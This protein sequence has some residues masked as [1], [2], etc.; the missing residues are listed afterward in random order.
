MAS[1]MALSSPVSLFQL[2]MLLFSFFFFFSFS[3]S[4]S[5][6]LN[7]TTDSLSLSFP[8]TSLPL[9]TAKPLNTNPKLRTLSSSSSYNIK[10]SFKYSMALVVTL[11]IGTPP[12]PQQMVLDTGSQ[13]SWI[14]CHNKTPPTA[15]FDPSLSSSF[16]VL[17]CTHPL[18]KPRVPDFTLP[19]TCDQN[20]LCH[21]SY[22]YADGTYAEGNLVREKLAF[23]P[24]Q[25]TPPLILGCS[26]ESRDARG[27]LG[28]NL[29][30]LS[31]PFQAKVT[32]FS[33]CVPTRQPANNNN[34]PTGSFYLGN[35][36]NSARFRYVSMLTF[37]QSQ[38]MPNLD[39]LA[40][41][42]PM[43]GIRIG[44]RKLNIPPSVFRPNAGG[45]GQTMVDSGSEFTFLVDVAYDRVRE[46][47]IRVL[48]PRVKKGYVYGGVADM[49][50][51]GNAMEIGR[52]LGD[53]AF[54]F[55]KGVEIVVPKERVLADVGGGVHCVGI[56]RSERLGAASNIIGNFH[57]Q[58]LWVEFDLANRRIG[59]G[60]ADCSRLSK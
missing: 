29:G 53:V 57:Q 34:F 11:P 9:S 14:Q 22:F 7:P 47:I 49:C 20:R 27:I 55:E 52:L 25:T 37:P 12:Q 24:S 44:G 28:M 45:S 13:L 5:A 35:N 10:S 3:T 32:K 21:Y 36:P 1:S 54:E 19:T 4:S 23:S 51:D 30:R 60:V 59:F 26:S 38:R 18:C 46:E 42:V 33:Y 56:G 58:N 15:S 6:K 43:Q 16:Y 2:C 31:F 39:P 50:F 8:L 41:T 17:P 48:G 40:Y